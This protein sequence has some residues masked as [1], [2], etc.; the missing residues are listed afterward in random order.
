MSVLAP[1][2]GGEDPLVPPSLV[3]KKRRAEEGPLASSVEAVPERDILM[4]RKLVSVKRKGSTMAKT[5][6]PVVKNII[7]DPDLV[8]VRG[9]NKVLRCRRC[10]TFVKQ[11]ASH[12]KGECDARLAAKANRKASKASGGRRKK[13]RMTPKRMAYIKQYV[14]DGAVAREVFKEMQKVEKWVARKESKLSGG[15]KKMFARVLEAFR[16]QPKKID[17][18][19]K[20][21]GL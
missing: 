6:V 7:V 20:H 5:S 17:S 4:P 12:P 21:C 19:F 14:Y 13:F 1:P 18:V 3:V 9:N 2:T 11:G 16:K 15:S 10:N 8:P